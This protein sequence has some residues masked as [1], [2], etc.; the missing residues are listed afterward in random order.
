MG[1]IIPGSQLH[2]L[3][4]AFC[5]ILAEKLTGF[6]LI[7]KFPTVYG[8]WR[9]IISFTS[10]CRLSLSSASLIQSLPPH[11]ASW[12]FSSIFSFQIRLGLPGGFF[13]SDFP[14]KTLYVLHP[15]TILVTCPTHLILL[16]F[17]TGT[18]L[19]R[20]YRS[21]SS[22]L[23]SFFH[24]PFT[25]SLLGP[26]ILLN[27]LFSKHPQPTFLPQCEQPSFTLIQMNRQNYIS[28]YLKLNFL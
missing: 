17:I 2:Y 21:L 4:T 12:R 13:L 26:D 19:G 3:L 28:M 10:A 18:L 20:I 24:L 25:S 11:L 6:H 15:S 22:S 1:T 14:S 7:K 8:T 5:T 16:N 23:Y 9:Y 27:T